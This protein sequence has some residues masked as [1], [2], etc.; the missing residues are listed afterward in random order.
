MRTIATILTSLR[1]LRQPHRPRRVKS[2]D[3]PALSSMITFHPAANGA[4][5]RPSDEPGD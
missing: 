5:A 2:S 4:V 3:G 1:L